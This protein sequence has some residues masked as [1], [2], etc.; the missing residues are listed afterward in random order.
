M[1]APAILKAMAYRLADVCTGG[2]GVLR[3]INGESI[4]FPVRWSRYYPSDYDPPK[5]AFLRA[6]C[7]TGDVVLDIGAHIGLF[8]IF[9][10]KL[11]GPTG[12]VFSF[13]PTPFTRQVLRQTVALN[14][15]EEI[16]VIRPEAV[17][18]SCGNGILYDTGV[19]LSNA[20]T[21]VEGLGRSPKSVPVQTTTIDEFVAAHGL[22]V[23]CIKVD[24]EGA[25]LD[26]LAGA[27]QT[28]LNVGPAMEIELHPATLK[29]S[30]RTLVDA[31][32]LF[33][34]YRLALYHEGQQVD[35]DWLCRQ[36]EAVDVQLLPKA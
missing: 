12:R 22:R 30:G 20:N 11:V 18:G 1:L 14:G 34:R 27:A 8:S 25:E 31:W 24:V 6:H 28:V 13:E 29:R 33:E 17:A 3:R 19:D 26:V 7:R 35:R 5:C 2:K 16:V 21:L 32:N 9:M 4:R 10:A 23:S 36:E 15:C